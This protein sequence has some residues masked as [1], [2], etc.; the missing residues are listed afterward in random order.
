MIFNDHQI[1]IELEAIAKAMSDLRSKIDQKPD[2][3]EKDAYERIADLEVKMAKLWSLLTEQNQM[4]KDKLTKFG[5]RFGGA[6]Q[7]NR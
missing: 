3:L 1:K 2:R 6:M 4:G 7:N 5:R